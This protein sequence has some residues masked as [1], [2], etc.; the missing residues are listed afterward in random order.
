M[1]GG[2]LRSIK[3]NAEDLLVGSK[4]NWLEVNA[5]KTNMF[6]ARD[7]NAGRNHQIQIEKMV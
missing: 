6:I 1:M 4:Q 7:Q 3:E 5:D 2:S